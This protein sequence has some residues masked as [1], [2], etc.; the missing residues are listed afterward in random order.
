MVNVVNMVG[1]HA[2]E[3]VLKEAC[4]ICDGDLQ[5]RISAEGARTWCPTCRLIMHPRVQVTPEGLFLTP[6][7]PVLA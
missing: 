5:L 6:E 4:P 2:A 1:D 3:T 7:K